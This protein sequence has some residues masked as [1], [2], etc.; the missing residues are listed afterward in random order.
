MS[1]LKRIAE[2]FKEFSKGTRDDF[3]EPDEQD[4]QLHGIVGTVLDNAFG[5][6]IKTGLFQ[7]GSHNVVLFVRRSSTYYEFN[8]ADIFALAKIGATQLTRYQ[9]EEKKKN[10]RNNN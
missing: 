3:H 9:I 10:E 4:I 8:L 6:S 1:M 7:Y 2:E 5:T